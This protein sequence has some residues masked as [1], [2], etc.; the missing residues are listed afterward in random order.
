MASITDFEDLEIWKDARAMNKK[1]Q[2]ATKRKIFDEDRDLRWQIRRASV[3]AMSNI[4]EGF[5]RN[6]NNFFIQFLRTAKGSAGE[7]RSQLYTCRDAECISQHE[8]APLRDEAKLLGQ[9]I[10]KL[11]D[12]LEAYQRLPGNATRNTVQGRRNPQPP[13][14]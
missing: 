1:V 10:G 8:I 6:N 4:A 5:E 13:N 9:R 11:M 14:P 7:V 2:Q 3:S 12:H